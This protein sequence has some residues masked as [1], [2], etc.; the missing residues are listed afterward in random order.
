MKLARGEFRKDPTGKKRVRKEGTSFRRPCQK[1]NFE[2]K[3]EVKGEDT[4]PGGRGERERKT[5]I[6]VSVQA[7]TRGGTAKARLGNNWRI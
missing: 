3:K 1:T 6:R 7:Q 4:S 2:P 5:K